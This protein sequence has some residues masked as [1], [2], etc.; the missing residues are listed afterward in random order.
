MQPCETK[1]LPLS[2]R[3]ID[4][5]LSDWVLQPALLTFHEP[6]QVGPTQRGVDIGVT[7]SALGVKIRP[8]KAL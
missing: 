4:P 7:V 8:E 2:Q 5:S 1:K 6:A 3:E